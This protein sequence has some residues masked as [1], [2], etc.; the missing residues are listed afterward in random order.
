M[1]STTTYILIG[2]IAL[3]V[4][5]VAVLVWSTLH[6]QRELRQKN[7][8]IIREIREN[9]QLRDELRRRLNRAVS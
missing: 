8:A 7:E 5:I 2:I 1:H 3:L 4:V 6:S 9:V